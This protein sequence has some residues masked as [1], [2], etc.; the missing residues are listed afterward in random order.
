MSSHKLPAGTYGITEQPVM[1]FDDE[2]EARG[3]IADA[4]AR[5]PL[6]LGDH[7]RLVL[8]DIDEDGE[9]PRFLVAVEGDAR[10]LVE[11]GYQ[12]GDAVVSDLGIDEPHGLTM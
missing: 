2:G 5:D 11:A 3:F 8:G 4:E 9:N 6:G 12:Y 1:W 7:L 10:R